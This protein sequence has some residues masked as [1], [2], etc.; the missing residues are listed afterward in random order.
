V[1]KLRGFGFGKST[2]QKKFDFGIENDLMLILFFLQKSN[3][4]E[5]ISIDFTMKY[6]NCIIDF[7]GKYLNRKNF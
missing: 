2:D 1:G 6:V 5:K 7:H 3:S 4:K